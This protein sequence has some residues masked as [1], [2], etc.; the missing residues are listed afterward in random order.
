[1]ALRYTHAQQCSCREAF[2]SGLAHLKDEHVRPEILASWKRSQKFGVLPGALPPPST[3]REKPFTASACS[4]RTFFLGPAFADFAEHLHTIGAVYMLLYEDMTV[5][6]SGGDSA[7]REKLARLHIGPG[8]CFSEAYMGTTALAL[9][10]ASESEN[11]GWVIGAEHYLDCLQ[12]FAT[13]ARW[14]CDDCSKYLFCVIVPQELFTESFL[15]LLSYFHQLRSLS[16]DLHRAVSELARQRELFNQ[17]KNI[18]EEVLMLVDFSQKIIGVNKPFETHFELT[19]D[20][21]VN[22][23]LTE[24]LPELENMMICLR[25]GKSITLSETHFEGLPPKRR[26]MFV[27]CTPWKRNGIVNGMVLSFSNNKRLVGEPICENIPAK[28]RYTFD[29]LIGNSIVFRE[30]KKMARGVASSNSSIILT[31]ESGTGK[32]L[33]ARAIHNESIRQKKPFVAV[34]CSAIP[35]ELIGSELFGYGDGAFTGARKGGAVGKFEYAHGGTLFLDEVA[36]LP[37]DVQSILLRVLEERA[38][39]RIGTNTVI[40]VNV[41]LIAATNKNLFQM[42]KENTFRLDLYYRLNV[43]TLELPP[44]RTR[45]GDISL[46]VE[47]FLESL[48][49][50]LDK[51]VTSVSPEAMD[52]LTHH[53]WPGN[54]RQLRNVVERGVN[55]AVT[56]MLRLEDLPREITASQYVLPAP[57]TLLQKAQT[58]SGEG[59]NYANWERSQIWEL[60]QKYRANKSRIAEEMGMSRGTLYKK[61]RLYGL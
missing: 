3:E 2:F 16:A 15:A 37:L 44:L 60:M 46:L 26:T 27:S 52:C 14:S 29:D 36:E 19:Q 24:I 17:L 41:R 10:Q 61:I 40:P 53:E 34:N 57:A 4:K 6:C 50:T 56:N 49:L 21:V 39:V 12:D 38:V 47:S 22:H 43:I 25:T 35:K 23:D 45:T 54:I 28:D 8:T 13:Y 42:V 33:F 9:A 1:M 7:L 48:S 5:F 59:V 20:D 51:E 30:I 11:E 31:G 32:E 18:Q 55:M 58:E